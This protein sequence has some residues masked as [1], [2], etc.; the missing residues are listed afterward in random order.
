L[1]VYDFS[2]KALRQLTWAASSVIDERDLVE[3][4]IKRFR[5]FDGLEIPGLLYR[6]KNASPQNKKPALVW[7]HGGPGGQSR[8]NYNPL[9]QYL[10]NHGYAVYAINNRGSSGYGKY[11]FKAD[12]R[13]HGRADLDDCVASKSMLI[14]TGYVDPDRIG[15]MGKSYGG[16]ITLAAMS[17]RPKEFAVGVD[18]FGISNWVRTLESMPAWWE[19]QRE[20]LF[21]EIGHPQMDRQYLNSISPLLHAEKIKN[22]LMVLQ[23][24]NDP[25]V[26]KAESDDIV[27]AVRKNGTPVT[28]IVFEDEGHGFRKKANKVTA[29]KAIRE[30]L[31]KHLKGKR[32]LGKAS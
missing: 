1:Y 14:N 7:V 18:I 24:R 22:P 19:S 32:S 15:I 28:Y 10:V 21:I 27:S 26:I 6:P 13:R 25:R 3:A 12:D 31:D 29:Y 8:D 30:F 11:F 9:I 17:F 16:F 2:K 4:E 23:G 20:A 5:S